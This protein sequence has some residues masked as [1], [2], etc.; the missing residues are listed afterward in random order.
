MAPR[1]CFARLAREDDLADAA[2]VCGRFIRLRAFRDGEPWCS[3]EQFD[4]PIQDRCP[5]RALGLPPLTHC[6]VGEEVRPSEFGGFG[7][8]ALSEDVGMRLEQ[9][10]NLWG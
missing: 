1:T 10:D 3:A 9:T 7:Q 4:V 2:R 5:Q 8:L 6:V